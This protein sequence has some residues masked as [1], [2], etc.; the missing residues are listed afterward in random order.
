M[1][2]NVL[3]DVYERLKATPSRLEKTALIADFIGK[4]PA[5]DLPIIVTFLT[6]RIF[7]GWDQRKTGIASQSMI[8]IISTITHNS[9]AMVVDSYK[10]SRATRADGRGDVREAEAADVLRAGGRHGQG[11]VRRSSPIWPG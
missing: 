6:G 7:P 2:F 10:H 5:D 4:V 11:A 3:V 8:K 9:E 1:L